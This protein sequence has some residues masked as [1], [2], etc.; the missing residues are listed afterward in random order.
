MGSAVHG[1]YFGKL[2]LTC[3]VFVL[4]VK[5]GLGHSLQRAWIP[6]MLSDGRF[7]Y[8]GYEL[9]VYCWIYIDSISSQTGMRSAALF[10]SE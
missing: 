1:F 6:L 7:G 3:R 10:R 2:L 4:L 9:L 8:Y 5:D